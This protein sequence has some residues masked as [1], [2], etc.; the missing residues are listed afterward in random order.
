[1]SDAIEAEPGTTPPRH[2]APSAY[3]I[4]TALAAWQAARARL[5]QEDPSLEYDEAALVDLL[6][7]E[8]GDVDSILA[9]LLRA[10]VHAESM[11]D[12]ADEQAKKIAG[13]KVRYERRGQSLRGTTFAIMDALGKRRHE[14]GDLTAN[15]A[16]GRQG[17]RVTDEK[18]IPDIYVEEVTERKIDKA[19]I[20]SALR[21]GL[22]V[23][24]AELGN[25]L[26]YLVIRGS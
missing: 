9:R 14:M 25:G 11:A 8:E 5:L 1:M 4:E 24:G 7:P 13:R 20:L 2:D 3:R 26:D 10:A 15:I 18:L 21:S 16:T 12:A 19:T 22:T 6:G 23:T 17:V